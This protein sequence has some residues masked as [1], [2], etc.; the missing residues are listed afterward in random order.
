MKYYKDSE[1]YV[2]S[3]EEDGSQDHLIEDKTEMTAKEIEAHINPQ[4]TQEQIKAEILAQI[5]NL[6]SQQLRALRELLIDASKE[7][8]K[9]KL[10]SIDAQIAE[11]RKQL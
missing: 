7:Y 1:G 10:E 11:L 8:A 3:Y 5:S 9:S 2:Y 4:K 6:E